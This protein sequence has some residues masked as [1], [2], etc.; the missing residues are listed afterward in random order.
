MY[1]N[2]TFLIFIY[3]L[4]FRLALEKSATS[5]TAIETITY[6]IKEYE[7]HN[8]GEESCAFAFVICDPISAWILN[9][10]GKLWAAEKINDQYRCIGGGFTIETKI[11]KCSENLQ[12]EC[13]S[14]ALW[15]STVSI[16]ND[17]RQSSYFIILIIS[18]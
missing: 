7:K 12:D 3:T 1:Q 13:K 18:T 17:R 4:I 5:E 9:I 16:T 15:D 14:L 11:D 6:L 10:V 8:V 2:T